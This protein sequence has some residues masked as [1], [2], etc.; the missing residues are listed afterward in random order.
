[1]EIVAAKDEQLQLINA[2]LEK[3]ENGT[4]GVCIMCGSQIPLTRLRLLPYV[5]RCKE[6][7]DIYERNRRRHDV[8]WA[9]M[10]NGMPSGD[11]VEAPEEPLPEE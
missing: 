4:Y 6:C 9:L 11:E 2:A 1:M 3:V 10:N 5:L 7:R 8:N